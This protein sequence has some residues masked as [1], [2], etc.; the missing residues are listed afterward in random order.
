MNSLIDSK[1]WVK[2]TSIKSRY[3]LIRLPSFMMIPWNWRAF[4]GIVRFRLLSRVW[5]VGRHQRYRFRQ[6]RTWFRLL[7][8]LTSSMQPMSAKS[9]L[10]QWSP[11]TVS[12]GLQGRSWLTE[13]LL[14][15]IEPALKKTYVVFVVVS[16]WTCFVKMRSVLVDSSNQK[17][18]S[19]WSFWGLLS[20]V[21][22]FWLKGTFT[23]SNLVY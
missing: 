12:N 17:T 11:W 13:I 2:Q 15:S 21:L 14:Q 8:K 1:E 16:A 10:P 23:F 9:F 22:R 19:V 6:S 7:Q 4:T 18:D 20:L 3:S 5:R